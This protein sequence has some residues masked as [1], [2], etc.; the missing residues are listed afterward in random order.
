M[1]GPL[2]LHVD[3]RWEL[4]APTRRVILGRGDGADI[5]LGCA[6]IS[7]RHAVLEPTAQGWT[8]TDLSRNGTFHDGRRVNQIVISDPTTVSM[9]APRNGVRITLVPTAPAAAE[10]GRLSTVIHSPASLIRIGRQPDNDVVLDDLLVSRHHAE[11][12]RT[13]GGWEVIDLVS[14]NGTFV[15]GRRVSRA[16]VA[17]HDVIGI[18]RGLL[19]LHG[20]HVVAYVDEGDNAFEAVGVSVT[21]PDG[22][23]LVHDVGF[24]VPGRSLLAVIGPSGAGKSTLLAALVGTRP[25]DVGDVRYAGRSL[26]ADYPELRHRIALVPQDDVLHTQLTVAEALTYAAR[27]RFSAD[28]T[29]ADRQRRVAEVLAELGLTEQAHQRI[30]QLS[31]G[32]RKRTSVAL[33]LLTKP[34]LLFL[35]EPTSGLDPGKDR[36]VMQTL[37]A[38]ADD[39]RTVVVVTHNVANLELCDRLLLLAAGGWLAYFGPPAEALAYFGRDDFADIFLLLEQAP[40]ENWGRRF[41]E[42]P[43]YERYVGAPRDRR[44]PPSRSSLSLAPRRQGHLVQLVI[45]CRR[46]LAVIAADRHYTW[47]SSSFC[48]CS[49]EPAGPAPCPDRPGCRCRLAPRPVTRSPVSCCSSSSSAGR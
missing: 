48:P 8:L 3:G 30:T 17:A 6:E 49:F 42:S 2:E 10:Q 9:G 38:L 15:N 46:Y 45:L 5:D 27:L 19:Q 7:R 16:A 44:P 28:T 21:T 41:R 14:G 29:A 13:P 18:G 24:A 39:G 40:G 43:L 31:G 34:S 35:D 22:T 47:S 23:T 36:S 20:D 32:Q 1:T 33:E 26:Y 37:R 12:R 25:A 4:L 11:L